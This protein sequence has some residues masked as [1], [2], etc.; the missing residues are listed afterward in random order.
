MLDNLGSAQGR[1]AAEKATTRRRPRVALLTVGTPSGARGGAERL[2]EGLH[3]ALKRSECEPERIELTSD[4]GDFDSVL[5]S[6][7]RFYDADLSAFDGVISTKAPSYVVRH[8]NHVAYLMHTMRVFYDMYDESGP[9]SPRRA[10]QRDVIHRIDTAAFRRPGVKA[11][12]AVGHEVRDRLLAFN[13]VAAECLHHPSTL[14][15]RRGEGGRHLL[16]AG[17]LHR[18][19]RVDLA[20]AAVRRMRRPIDVIVTGTGEDE[21]R[22]RQAAAGMA[23]VRFAG[24]VGD[25]ELA[26]LYAEALAVVYCPL[27]EDFG[28]VTVEAFASGT[29]VVTCRDSGEPA[30]LVE[31][32]VNGWVTAPE[33]AAMAARLD[34]LVENRA[35]AAEMGARGLAV[36]AGIAWQPVCRR[37]LQALGFPVFAA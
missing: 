29:P 9:P 8:R 14:S 21:A 13:G 6:Y 37:L 18:W 26:A 5:R 30:R 11:V 3:E 12:F 25:E 23:G 36:A 33:P 20:L 10:A 7:L 15:C 34:W 35:A 24:H 19:K 17:R 28:L 1:F 2:Y 16:V 27:R 4:E 31:D 32:G 22:L